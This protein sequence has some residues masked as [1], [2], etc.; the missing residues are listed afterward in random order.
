[1]LRFSVKTALYT[2]C[3]QPLRPLWGRVEASELGYRLAKGVFWSMAGA[4]ISRGL[5]F[6]AFVLVA[7]MLGKTE[8]GELG[9]IRSTAGMFAVF[10]GFGLGLTANKHVAELHRSAPDRAG[11]IIA[12]SSLVA[13]G[14][15][16][17]MALVLFVLAPW[18]A[19]NTLAAP[20]LSGL[21]RISCLILLL[22]ALSGAQ[23]GALA[24]FEA[25]KVIAGVNLF[26]GLASFPI[27]IGGAYWGGLEGA[28]WGLAL[29]LAIQWT[30]NHVALRREAARASI[31]F[32]FTG[33]TREWG[34]LWQFSL[35]A[36]LSGVVVAPL[37]WVAFAMLVNQPAGYA[38]MGIYGAALTFQS[39]LLFIGSTLN[40]P[41]L[42][43]ISNTGSRV[44]DKLDRVNIAS[45]WLIGIVP[46]LPLLCFPEMAG[47]LFG[48][49]Y[50]GSEFCRTF[51]IVVLYTC[52]MLY[53]DGLARVLV[54]NSL[55]WWGFASNLVWGV[56][57]LAG[58]LFMVPWGAPG[59]AGAF[60]LAYV[61]NVAIF[62]PL[63]TVK[64]LVPRNTI[65]SRHAGVV[66]LV[67][68][69][70]TVCGVLE[71]NILLRVAILAVG[72]VLLFV[73]VKRM[74]VAP[75]RVEQREAC[76]Q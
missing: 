56:V 43:M 7:R 36:A 76:N 16:G 39:V 66:W 71:A 75:T 4:V 37:Q 2:C 5:M 68:L 30:F 12:L 74:M 20:Q 50:S 32:T 38:E 69:V 65:V 41:M 27:L 40:A 1:M 28:V 29:N 11:R 54:A 57:L 44:N 72:S 10:A 15:G 26:V 3:P 53:K 47:M 62:I 64:R 22:N 18:L 23:T 25:F 9:V 8:F 42:S 58:F 24:G 6:V 60:L 31:P 45:S 13:V 59:L 67:I 33:C 55:L 70:A 35:P 19:A 49:E 61:V 21:L 73:G 48:A 51:C 14:T 17:L 34:I 52:I 63:Y 46:A